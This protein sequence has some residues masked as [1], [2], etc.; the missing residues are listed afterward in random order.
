MEA[1]LSAIARGRAA[2]DAHP[3]YAWMA[4]R[5]RPVG[6]AVRLRAALRQLHPRLQRPQPLVPALPGAPRRLR[7]RHQ[8]AHRGGRDALGAVPRRLARAGLR[9][10]ARLGRRGHDGLVLHGTRDRGVP[11]LRHAAHPD[12]RRDARPARPVRADGGHRDL[13]ARLLRAHRPVGRGA[14]PAHRRGAALLRPVPPRAGDRHVDRRRR[15][16][17]ER[18]PHPRAASARRR[19]GRGG[20]R[21]VHGEERPPARVR[22]GRHVGGGGAPARAGGPARGRAR[23]RRCGR[24]TPSSRAQP[25]RWASGS[26]SGRRRWPRTRSWRGWPRPPPTRSRGCA[27]S[28]RCGSRTSWAT[29]TS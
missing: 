11:P 14:V 4:D 7:G 10:R 29:P 18:R 28:C 12:V 20:V 5:G 8:R 15:P 1:V 6:Q 2:I 22:A 21:D 19:A 9:R 23:R 24:C 27:R 13:R 17:R 26:P 25:V 3:L 16:L